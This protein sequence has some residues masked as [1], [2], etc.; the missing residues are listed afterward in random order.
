MEHARLLHETP[1]QREEG[2]EFSLIQTPGG[3]RAART[4]GGAEGSRAE[5][6]AEGWPL[7][8]PGETW[9]VGRMGHEVAKVRAQMRA[10]SAEE[11]R[12][13]VARQARLAASPA[14][15]ARLPDRGARCRATLAT[16]QTLLAERE[17]EEALAAKMGGLRIDTERMEWGRALDSDDDSDP[18]GEPRSPLAVLAQGL[19]PRQ[20]ARARGQGEE[21]SAREEVQGEQVERF[22]TLQASRVDQLAPSNKFSPHSSAKQMV[23]DPALRLSLGET[24]TSTVTSTTAPTTSTSVSRSPMMP[25]PP[26]YTCTTTRLT[27]AESLQLQ[28]E[29]EARARGAAVR[30]AQARLSTSALAPGEPVEQ[31][32]FLEYRRPGE[33]SEE[34]EDSGDEG[35]GVVGVTVEA[36]E[37]EE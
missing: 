20:A 7:K 13:V 17:G 12:E 27:L 28:Q 16:L 23:L 4:E 10:K 32:R 3:A 11:L 21:T 37:E 22:A 19:V 1:Y 34:E 29:Q 36:K 26:S 35:V 14:L 6:G 33:V 31:G 9:G 24:T 25:L 8:V 15:L 2:G 30:V 18:E 5:G